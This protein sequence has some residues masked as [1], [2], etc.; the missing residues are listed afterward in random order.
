MQEPPPKG[1]RPRLSALVW[2]LYRTNG[3]E[4]LVADDGFDHFLVGEAPQRSLGAK[5]VVV[6]HRVFPE[7][8][9]RDNHGEIPGGRSFACFPN[10][11]FFGH[12]C[13]IGKPGPKP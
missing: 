5:P 1:T 3:A 13:C 10:R 12:V 9:V 6:G 11:S 7:G 4:T 8:I 2:L